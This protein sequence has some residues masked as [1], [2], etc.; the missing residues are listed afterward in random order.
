MKAAVVKFLQTTAGLSDLTMEQVEDLEIRPKEGT[1]PPNVEVEVTFQLRV[2]PDLVDQVNAVWNP[3]EPMAQGSDALAAL[4]S[5]LKESVNENDELNTD[6]TVPETGGVETVIVTT[7]TTTTTLDPNSSPPPTQLRALQFGLNAGETKTTEESQALLAS[8]DFRNAIVIGLRTFFVEKNPELSEDLSLEDFHPVDIS[9]ASGGGAASALSSF[10]QM[11]QKKTGLWSSTTTR[12]SRLLQE[13]R[14]SGSKR[15]AFTPSPTR[16]SPSSPS[17]PHTADESPHNETTFASVKKSRKPRKLIRAD[18]EEGDLHDLQQQEQRVLVRSR[19]EAESSF[20]EEDHSEINAKVALKR[21]KSSLAV[22]VQFGITPSSA[23]LEQKLNN[24]WPSVPAGSI[25]TPADESTLGS[26]AAMS[27]LVTTLGQSVATVDYSITLTSNPTSNDEQEKIEE[28]PREESA[29]DS[30]DSQD[31]T[32]MLLVGAGGLLLLLLLGGLLL[33]R[34]AAPAGGAGALPS[35]SG[36]NRGAAARRQRP[37][38]QARGSGSAS[39]SSSSSSS[40]TDG[41]EKRTARGKNRKKMLMLTQTLR[42]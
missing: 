2:E 21:M 11:K 8:A 31:F 40:S 19:S 17:L 26:A 29:Y 9:L 33:Q 28:A 1:Q 35:A 36:N 30:G 34:G 37:A 13:E 27:S 25:P 6:M 23:D 7:T 32:K 18:Y 41:G 15:T 38:A 4:G 3:D 42:L 16:T 39:S 20:L 24:V 14:R 10:I 12:G 5:A 22:N